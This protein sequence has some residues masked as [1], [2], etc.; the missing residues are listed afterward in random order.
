[1]NNL[2]LNEI[3]KATGGKPLTVA[4]K[5]FAGVSI[6]S[7]TIREGELFV[8]IRG[9]TFDG[10][11]FLH[12]A[13]K[14]GAGA[15]TGV[16]GQE[17]EG[18]TL[19]YTADTLRALQ[20]LA[21]H[22]RIKMKV[23]VAGV[24]GTNG[25][26]T[27]KE[28]LASILGRSRSVLKT[29]GNFNNHIGL[30]LSIANMRGNEAAMVL[31]M[32]SNAPGDIRLLCEIGKPDIALVTN[33]G[34]AHLEGFGS[35]ETVRETDL[36]IL[37]YVKTACMNADDLFLMEGV[38][39]FGGKIVT[40]GIERDADVRADEISLKGKGSAF[41]LSFKKGYQIAVSLLIAG[42][43]NI[44]NA[45][46]A[47]SVANELGVPP[48][49]VKKGLE[50]FSGVPMR[51]EIK[52]QF[53]AVVI[54]DVYNANPAS[55][56]EAVMELIRMKKQRAV[57]VLGDMLEL[58]K[59]S[60]DAHREL[61]RWISECGVEILI[62]VGPEMGRASSEFSGTCYRAEDSSAARS[63]LL[64]VV[65]AGDAVLVKGSRGMYMEKVLADP[66]V[67]VAKGKSHAV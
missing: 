51:L 59:F 6:D 65:N 16:P 52:E 46:A 9:A 54:S 26:T 62:A 30:P 41:R 21:K 61:A 57:A 45:L 31:E 35:L 47:A 27:T 1:M 58:G 25:K 56:R 3:V 36:E 60:A 18:K 49:D 66:A 5:E 38:K 53:G 63:V 40:Y 50:S 2:T 33:V 11:A 15:L 12:D 34:P 39:D 10:H 29:R 48:E 55:M 28:L 8:P 20:D 4:R 14:R 67:T 42:R 17:I 24:T 37:D 64:S 13:L 22:M 32:G 43:F 7:R 19:I 23:P 44:Y